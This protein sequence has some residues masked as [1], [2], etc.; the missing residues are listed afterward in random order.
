EAKER[1]HKEL[2]I[3]ITISWKKVVDA[4]GIVIDGVASPRVEMVGRVDKKIFD[5]D[6]KVFEVT[7]DVAGIGGPTG[8]INSDGSLE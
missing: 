5:H 3:A 1:V 6:Q 4:F 2:G 8:I 7:H